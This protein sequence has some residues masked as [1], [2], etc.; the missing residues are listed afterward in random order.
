MTI[1][2]Q[3]ADGTI[4]EFPDG[5][6]PAVIQRTVKKTIAQ[7]Q[8]QEAIENDISIPEQIVGGVS[9]AATLASDIIGTG[10]GGLTALVDVLNPFTDNDPEQL[11][12]QVKAK[13]R[14]DPSQGGE[15]ALNQLGEAI[16]PIEPIINAVSE[17]KE[18]AGQQGLDLTGSPA[19]A[20]FVNI[21]PDIIAEVGGAGIARGAAT[22]SALSPVT[23]QAKRSA[24]SAIDS[25][26]SATGIK[27]LTSDI[28]P[29]ET[30]LGKLLQ[31]QGELVA[32]FQRK[33]QQAQRVR[34]IENLAN[35]FDVVEGA[36]FESKIVKGLKE[37]IQSSKQAIGELYDQS[38][39][40]LDGLGNVPLTR[41]KRFAQDIIDRELKKGTKANQAVIDDMQS[42]VD[43]PDDLSF[44]LIKEIRSSVGANLEKV[45]RG[46]PVQGNTDTSLLKRTYKQ[47]TND[48]VDFADNVDPELSAKWKKANDTVSEFALGN[49]KQGAKAIIKSGDATPEVVDRLLF[50]NKNSDLEFLAS[51]L[52]DTGKKA[53]KQRILQRVLEKSSIDGDDINPNKF[54]SQLNKN[55]NQIG[56]MFDVEERKSIF[57]LRD[58]LA[59]TKRAQ[60]ASVATPTGQQL[61]IGAA[62][63]LPQ[64]LLPGV[65]QGFIESKPIRNLLVKRKAAKTARA[66]SSIDGQLKNEIN[67]LSLTGALTAGAITEQGQ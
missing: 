22:R 11:I 35:K 5:T 46:A 29:P 39:A 7:S 34:A 42:F 63:A 64:A 54:L 28:L 12:E 65:V 21:I 62:L 50:S 55:R 25:A 19:F 52:D 16:K 60:D 30:R 57:A 3:L 6:D 13:L 33:G 18:T 26:D 66:I 40:K 23:S 14:I 48:M 15:A 44:E 1:Q 4:L 45:K 36:G 47:L 20:T 27:Q 32:G 38:S 53:A 31:S 24:I 61:T 9:G 43:A 49:S 10:V 8:Q 2:A 56:K 59:Q 17:F 67:K 37:S 51:N 58:Q 41:T